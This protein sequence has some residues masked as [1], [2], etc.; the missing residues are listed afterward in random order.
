MWDG[1]SDGQTVY[2]VDIKQIDSR[3][4]RTVKTLDARKKILAAKAIGTTTKQAD[5]LIFTTSV[6]S[7][8]KVWLLMSTV[9]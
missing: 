9:Y 6:S 8:R 4:T 1:Q 5:F 2:P 3:F 7:G